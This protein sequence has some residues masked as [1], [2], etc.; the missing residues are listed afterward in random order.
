MTAASMVVHSAGFIIERQRIE[1][2]GAEV[3]SRIAVDVVGDAVVVDQ[4]LRLPASG[5]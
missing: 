5:A 2:P 3:L 1:R 4:P